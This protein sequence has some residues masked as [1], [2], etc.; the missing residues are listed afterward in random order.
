MVKFDEGHIEPDSTN[1]VN[2][3][4]RWLFKWFVFF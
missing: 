4:K 2:S 3:Q 1:Q